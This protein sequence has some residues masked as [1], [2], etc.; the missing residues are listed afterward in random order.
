MITFKYIEYKSTAYI[1]YD[2]PLLFFLRDFNEPNNPFSNKNFFVT[3]KET[4]TSGSPTH[5]IQNVSIQYRMEAVPTCTIKYE[6]KDKLL[7]IYVC[8][9]ILLNE[10][11]FYPFSKLFLND[12][13]IPDIPVDHIKLFSIMYEAHKGYSNFGNNSFKIEFDNTENGLDIY[14]Y[15][16]ALL[17]YIIDENHE[18][19]FFYDKELER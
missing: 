13:E 3:A 17:F 7:A 10:F 15:N 9:N 1:M 8:V 14:Q 4:Y 12:I 5:L 6:G 2:T 11:G 19:D 18:D 16:K